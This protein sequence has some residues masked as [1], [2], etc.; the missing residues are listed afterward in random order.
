MHFSL[1]TYHKRPNK[2]TRFHPKKAWRRIS[3]TQEAAIRATVGAQPWD[4][5]YASRI[6]SFSFVTP[7]STLPFS[8][9]LCKIA[10]PLSKAQSRY[11]TFTRSLRLVLLK[12]MSFLVFQSTQHTT[13]APHIT[14]CLWFLGKDFIQSPNFYSL[15]LD[16][17]HPNLHNLLGDTRCAS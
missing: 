14:R 10:Q 16:Q 6:I 13:E 8:W 1:Q 3:N 12:H 7:S 15:L 2:S 9:F 11:I 4:L 17:A 5:V